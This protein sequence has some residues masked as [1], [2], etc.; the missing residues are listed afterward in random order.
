MIDRRSFRLT[1]LAG[2][3]ALPLAAEAQSAGKVYRVG[4]I[5]P[6]SVAELISDFN[7]RFNTGG[8]GHR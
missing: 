7:P 8:S 3:F 1:S 6:T 5:P 4:W 2:G